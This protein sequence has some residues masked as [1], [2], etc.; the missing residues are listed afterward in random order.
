MALA[1]SIAPRP[2][3]LLMDEPFSNLDRR[4]R[5]AIRDETVAILRETGAT[6]IVVT[7]DPEEAMRIADRIVLMRA[8]RIMQAGHGRGDSTAARP[9]SS[10]RASS[11]T[12]TRS[13]ASAAAGG[14]RRRSGS[15]A[16]PQVAGRRRRHRLH[17]AAGRAA[18]APP[19]SACRAACCRGASSARSSS[20]RSRSRASTAR[21][22]RGCAGRRCVNAG[23]D[24][25]VEIDP[26][27]VLV[28]AAG[29]PLGWR[30]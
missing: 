14:S 6:T 7:H 30:Q 8:G 19:A 21:C 29:Q 2:G 26:D 18:Q 9:T 4:M 5:D 10:R 11:A 27:E 25:G 15:F 17:P 13:R 3:V 23:E 16:A 1:R 22:R 28:F 24:V 12:S 20:S